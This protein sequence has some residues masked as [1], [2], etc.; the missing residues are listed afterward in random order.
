MRPFER[1]L[2]K[3]LKHH[4]DSDPHFM[5][6]LLGP[7]QVG[8]TTLAEQI[9]SAWPGPK[10]MASADQALPPGPTWVKA[11][12]EPLASQS[13]VAKP[14]LLI[15][16]EVQKVHRWS[17]TVK[18]AWDVEQRKPRGLRVM[19][20]GSSSLLV[21]K[22]LSESLAGRFEMSR[23]QHWTFNECRQ[24][25]GLKFKDWLYFGGYPGALKLKKDWKAWSAYVRDSLVETALSRDVLQMQVIQKP[26]LL[27]HLFGLCT[28]YPAQIFSYNKMLGQLTDAGNTTT[29]AHYLT[30]LEAAFLA[31]GLPNF[32]EGQAIHRN[33]SPKL[34][35][36]NNAL[37]N[38]LSGR[39][40]QEAMQDLGWW[41]RVVEN[42]VGA[43]L[44]THLPK[45]THEV[46][47][48]RDGDKEVDFVVKTSRK[49]WA[50]EVKSGRPTATP[51]LEAFCK[52]YPRAMPMVIG[53]DGMPLEEFFMRDPE[54]MFG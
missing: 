20:L 54:E 47:Y 14:A 17:E 34:V 1:S 53:G 38:A 33:S 25:F 5:Q 21:Q 51:G 19:L 18:L 37:V 9:L 4:L 40:P 32:R 35:L 30:L 11:Q 3:T 44:L 28:A 41:G 52:R 42:A 16:D 48:W 45:M 12:W 31:S 7:R 26:A 6:V 22:G 36:W 2:L 8:K 13:S 29:L 23:C 43:H 27:R 50:L 10:A 15:L 24:A 46:S 39:G 49:L